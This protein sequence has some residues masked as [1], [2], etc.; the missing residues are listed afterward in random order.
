MADETIRNYWP[1]WEGEIEDAIRQTEY[2]NQYD[3]PEGAI[4]R[5]RLMQN[6]VLVLRAFVTMFAMVQDDDEER[7]E[8]EKP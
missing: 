7:A 1:G 2:I 4:R 6:S 3:D 8:K 5:D